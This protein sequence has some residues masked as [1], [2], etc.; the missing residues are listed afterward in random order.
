MQTAILEVSERSCSTYLMKILQIST[1]LT[2]GAGIA[3][4]R[5]HYSLLSAGADSTLVSLSKGISAPNSSLRTEHLVR[6]SPEKFMSFLLTRAQRSLIQ[7]GPYLQT[8]LSLGISPR[9]LQIDK[10]DLIHIHSMYNLINDSTLSRILEANIPVVITLHD[11]RLTTG[12]C[13]GSMGCTNYLKNC[14]NCPQ[15]YR[16]AQ[17]LVSKSANRLTSLINSYSDNILLIAPSD[18][19]KE[20]ANLRFPKVKSTLIFNCVEG[21]YLN[22]EKIKKN[23]NRNSRINIGFASV[24][25]HNPYKGFSTLMRALDLLGEARSNYRLVLFGNGD[26]NEKTENL[27]VLRLGEV[28]DENFL[29]AMSE[30]DV[31]VVPSDQD[32]LPN[33]MCEALCLGV[34]VIGSRVGGIPFVLDKFKLPMFTA[35]DFKELARM[36][37][38]VDMI[39]SLEVKKNLAKEMFSPFVHANN[40][41]SAYSEFTSA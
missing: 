3:A 5:S 30:I 16:Y 7:N 40:L 29:S 6:I 23:Q 32:N 35:G 11:Q 2:G 13:H 38:D 28:K 25:I 27:E 31:L 4:L 26:F 34:P 22:R 15:V 10:Y 8:P 9:R 19:I 1:S 36:L 39:R 41:L 14:R 20:I 12:G 33:V 37:S 24:N 17:P 18:W 21:K